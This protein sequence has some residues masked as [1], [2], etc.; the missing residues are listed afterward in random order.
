MAGKAQ[1]YLQERGDVL[2]CSGCSLSPASGYNRLVRGRD[3]DYRGEYLY[4]V[5]VHKYL[6]IASLVIAVLAAVIRLGRRQ[7]MKKWWLAGYC[8]LML[9]LVVSIALTGH[10]GGMLVHGQ[11]FLSDIF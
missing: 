9:A 2:S 11:G 3:R 10:Y 6:G 7:Q 1:G 5:T 4:I 8:V